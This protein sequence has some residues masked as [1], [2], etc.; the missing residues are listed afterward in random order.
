MDEKDNRLSFKQVRA[1]FTRTHPHQL[2]D[3]L[4]IS[5]PALLLLGKDLIG[6][7][8]VQIPVGDWYNKHAMFLAHPMCPILLHHVCK[9]VTISR[10]R[11]QRC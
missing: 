7:H 6:E 4:V 11:A 1:E 2:R 5:S 3:S 10:L 8:S 9:T